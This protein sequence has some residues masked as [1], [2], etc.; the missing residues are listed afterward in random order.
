MLFKFLA[1]LCCA[2][3]GAAENSIVHSHIDFIQR[4][5]KFNSSRKN[6]IYEEIDM[7]STWYCLFK[8]L[9]QSALKCHIL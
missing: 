7:K 5:A 4:S 8:T 9:F 2:V 1:C 3:H 6:T